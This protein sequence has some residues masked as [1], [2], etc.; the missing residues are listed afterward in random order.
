MLFHKLMGQSHTIGLVF[1]LLQP[2][3]YVVCL[4]VGYP[5][6]FHSFENFLLIYILEYAFQMLK[7]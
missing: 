6:C 4:P 7:I 2:D 5:S 1:A 3:I